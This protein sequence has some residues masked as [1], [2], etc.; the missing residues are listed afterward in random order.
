MKKLAIGVVAL[1]IVA[2]IAAVVIVGN[3]DKIIK[4]AI[5]GVGS[6]LMG[7]PVTVASV[8]ISLKDGGGQI[9]G[10]RIG[11]P[12]GYEAK[13]AFEMDLIRLKLDINSLKNQPI[14]IND[15]TIDK[16]VVSLEVKE[17]G[18]NNLQALMGNMEKNSAKAD[19]KAAEEQPT[20][21]STEKGEPVKIAFTE[22]NIKEVTVNVKTVVPEP[23]SET[24]VIPDII[25]KDV[26][27]TEGL[28]PAELGQKIVG[29][30]IAS[31]L[32][33]ALKKELTKQVEEAT[34]GFFEGIQ[35]KLSND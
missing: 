28:T 32:Q 24:V 8:E 1:I 17:D 5:E 19:E 33:N 23:K 29:D 26:G 10:M 34:K 31:S 2:G 11:N 21:E 27:G 35:K 20:T 12:A 13:N 15:L 6:E 18:T 16:P 22:L 14:I 3:L 7:V 25:L 9:T 30:I 4:G